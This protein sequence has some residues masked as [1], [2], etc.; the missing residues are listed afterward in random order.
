MPNK[1]QG[2]DLDRSADLISPG[3]DF[4][5]WD[6]NFYFLKAIEQLLVP[7]NG[8]MTIMRSLVQNTTNETKCDDI[9]HMC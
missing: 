8:V 3:N 1:G 7:I 5:N 6:P 4:R 2:S 9:V